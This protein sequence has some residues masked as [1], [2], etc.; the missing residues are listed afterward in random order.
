M[1]DQEH[2]VLVPVKPPAVGKSR[3]VGLTVEL[4]RELAVA[5]ALD[6]V[7]ACLAT[8]GV[9]AVLAVTDDAAFSQR[10]AALGCEAVPDGVTGDLNACLRLGAAEAVRR[11]PH[12]SPVALCADLPALRPD[13]LA[14]ALR[15]L[16]VSDPS[17]VADAAGTGTTMYAAPLDSFDPRFGPGSHAAHLDAGAVAVEGDL[18]SLRQ[19]VD[20]LDDLH[21]VLRLGV[22][23]HT[24]A[25][26]MDSGWAAVSGDPP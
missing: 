12:L 10:L 20:D 16:S 7:S 5:F 19:D 15:D 6:T 25:L 21:R 9:G 4:R 1:K 24:S 17:F 26:E 13:D 14:T 23:P 18:V 3:L 2:V 8:P 22:G 11:W